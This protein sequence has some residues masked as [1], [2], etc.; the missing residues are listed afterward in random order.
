MEIRRHSVRNI[1]EEHL[2]EP[3][4]LL[5]ASVG[6]TRG[7]FQLV[8]SSPAL[9]AQETAVAMGFPPSEEDRLWQEL[10]DGSIP[11]PL[12]FREM[13]QQVKHNPRAKDVAARFQAALRRLAARIPESGSALVLA[14][15]GVPELVAA[16]WFGPSVLEGLGPPCKCM[17]GIYLSLEGG[18]AVDVTVLRVH[19][20]RTRM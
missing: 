5:A 2:S 10:G 8:V 18:R 11:W 15:G 7:P 19:D 13:R 4:R 14:H 3:G 6:R 17:E 16:S 12:S 20:S 9:R 1:P